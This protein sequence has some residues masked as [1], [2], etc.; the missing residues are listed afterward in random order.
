MLAGDILAL[1]DD[2][3]QL[4]VAQVDLV[5][6]AGLA[7]E[8]ERDRRALDVDVAV[9]HRGQP[10]RFVLF[11][12]LVVADADQRRFQQVHDRRD[13][14][15]LRQSA[16]VQVLI[17]P[18]TDFRQRLPELDHVLVLRLFADLAPFLVIAVLL[19]PL[20]VT[21]G[22][23]EMAVRLRADPDVGPRRRD[24]ERLDALQRAFVGDAVTPRIAVEEAL[25]G[26]MAGD[27]GAV[28]AH[29][30]E[31]GFLGGLLR[32]INRFHTGSSVEGVSV[33]KAAVRLAAGRHGRSHAGMPGTKKREALSLPPRVVRLWWPLQ[34]VDEDHDRAR[35]GQD[36][37][38]RQHPPERRLLA[39]RAT[40][41]E[42]DGDHAQ[43]V[44]RVVDHRADQQ[45]LHR[46][47]E[48]VRV[49]AHRMVVDITARAR[50]A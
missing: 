18:L 4:A 43:A 20:A 50:S 12:V 30:D 40:G 2:A 5:L 9:A 26:A 8:V 17:D 3:G 33:L 28:R 39:H 34:L 23:L 31:A 32:I 22:G 29:I 7:V 48:R 36:D 47:D 6:H 42:V 44:Q 38:S 11:R 46:D 15:L 35:D 10:V 14:L 16:L 41:G 24:D 1:L 21:A 13:D 19:A 49:E 37:R 27:A 45:D 25:A